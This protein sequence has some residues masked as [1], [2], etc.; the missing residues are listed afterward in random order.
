MLYAFRQNCQRLTAMVDGDY[1]IAACA[2][3]NNMSSNETSGANDE[4]RLHLG[5]V[6]AGLMLSA[7][8]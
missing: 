6:A 4:Y 1:V 7:V 8:F 5:V 3:T 2:L